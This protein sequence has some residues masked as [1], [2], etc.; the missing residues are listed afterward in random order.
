M[1]ITK[2]Q[3]QRLVEAEIKAVSPEFIAGAPARKEQF[4]QRQAE[5]KAY[6]DEVI[7]EI[8]NLMRERMQV[9][10]VEG[11]LEILQRDYP[12]WVSAS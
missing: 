6:K 2:K 1:N 11:V 7:A 12:S 5:E 4:I 9:K 10:E 3:I 8:A